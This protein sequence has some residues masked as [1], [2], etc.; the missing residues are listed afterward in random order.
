M[1][2]T[3]TLHVELW[4]RR[5]AWFDRLE[6]AWEAQARVRYDIWSDTYQLERGRLPGF[7]TASLDSLEA[8]L[9]RPIA[10]RLASLATLRPGDRYY[11]ACI[12]TLKPLTVEDAR[13]IEG[14]LSGEVQ[15]KRRAG[16]GAITGLPLAVFDAVRNVVGL[17]DESGRAQSADFLLA[18]RETPEA[19]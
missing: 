5:A 10:L 14:W 3:L 9:E 6:G 17:G 18:E 1:P 8:E 19:P 13:E 2:A 16:L 12:A 15:S 11:V 4:R 7:A